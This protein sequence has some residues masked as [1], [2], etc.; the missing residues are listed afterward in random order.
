MVD[1]V[2]LE[3]PDTDDGTVVLWFGLVL[4]LYQHLD[5]AHGLEH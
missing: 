3:C 2:N 5:E 1:D 4:H